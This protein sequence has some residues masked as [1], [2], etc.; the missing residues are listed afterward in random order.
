MTSELISGG[1][2]RPARHLYN[3]STVWRSWPTTEYFRDI[4]D[5]RRVVL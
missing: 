1:T 3:P 4:N 5:F 2:Q